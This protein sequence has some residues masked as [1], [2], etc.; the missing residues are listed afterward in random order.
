MGKRLDFQYRQGIS[1]DGVLAHVLLPKIYLSQL[2]YL[3]AI[4]ET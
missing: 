1:N 3:L 4:F 2:L